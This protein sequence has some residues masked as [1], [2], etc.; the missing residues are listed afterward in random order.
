MQ[1]FA[2]HN[3]KGVYAQGNSECLSGEFGELRAY[4]ISK[5]LM[6]PYMTDK[7]YYAHMDEFLAAYYGAGWQNIRKYID[8]HTRYAKADPD[9]MGLYNYPFGALSKKSLGDLANSFNAWWDAAEAE[10]GDRLAYV[11]RS[12]WQ[13]QYMLLYVFPNKEEA[14]KLVAAVEGSGSMWSER[15]PKLL[16]YVYEYDLLSQSPDTW[17]T[18][19]SKK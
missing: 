1:F 15:D 2:E 13:L 6:N 4:L 7:E 12:R 14:E 8:T 9:G 16:W 18:D 11:Q 17:F 5:I 19:P 3:V 10:A